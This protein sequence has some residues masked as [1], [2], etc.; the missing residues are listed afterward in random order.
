MTTKIPAWSVDAVRAKVTNRQS[1]FASNASLTFV[2]I[3]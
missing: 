1:R 3:V 2:P